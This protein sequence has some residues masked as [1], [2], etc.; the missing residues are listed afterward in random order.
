VQAGVGQFHL[1]F[2]ARDVRDVDVR[3]PV[4]EM[5]EQR[6]L[7]DAGLSPEDEHGALTIACVFQ[8]PL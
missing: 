6:G 4:E 7:P 2:R 5:L 3:C 8:H 1:Q